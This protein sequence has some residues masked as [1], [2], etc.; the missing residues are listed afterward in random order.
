MNFKLLADLIVQLLNTK[1]FLFFA[2]DY[3][4]KW[5]LFYYY[6]KVI[7]MVKK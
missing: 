3:N 5:N 4:F 2:S 1:I 7:F 6:E